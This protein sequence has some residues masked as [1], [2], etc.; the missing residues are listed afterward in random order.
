[1]IVAAS[2]RASRPLTRHSL[3]SRLALDVLHD[4]RVDTVLAIDVKD[5]HQVRMVKHGRKL[6]LALKPQDKLLRSGGKMREQA[7]APHVNVELDVFAPIN[8]T[9][10][11]LPYT[12]VKH[13]RVENLATVNLR[14]V[15]E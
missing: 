6:G 8:R 9:H 15:A 10:A 14:H 12:R 13:A 7:L 5:A 4:E 1:M 3:S 11:S 2:P